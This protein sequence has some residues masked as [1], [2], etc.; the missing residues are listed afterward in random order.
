M[1]RDH[2]ETYACIRIEARRL[3]RHTHS[4]KPDFA[5]GLTKVDSLDYQSDSKTPGIWT[6]DCTETSSENIEGEP[7]RQEILDGFQARPQAS[8]STQGVRVGSL[9][10]EPVGDGA[11]GRWQRQRPGR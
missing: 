11:E 6:Y 7:C 4:W 8:G 5:L 1:R 10:R 3:A 2:S 9:W